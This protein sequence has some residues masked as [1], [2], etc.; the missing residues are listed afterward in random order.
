MQDE[1]A[2]PDF[3]ERLLGELAALHPQRAP[4]GRPVPERR[5]PGRPGP[6]RRGQP[7]RWRLAV[8]AVTGT[9]AAG[10]VAAVAIGTGPGS[11]PDPESEP[12]D[13][14]LVAER[15]LEATEAAGDA[16]VHETHRTATG[17]VEAETWYDE[18]TAA[19]RRL[20]MEPDG[21]PLYDSG[22]VAP[23]AVDAEPDPG[24]VR[25]E[26]GIGVCDPVSRLSMDAEGNITECDPGPVPPQP[27]VPARVV[28]HCSRSYAEVP[29]P[30]VVHPGS[31]YV[32]LFL[33][34]GDLVE[35]GTEEVDG[36]T[37]LR[38]RNHD[39]STVM[40]VDPETYLPASI[41]TTLPRSATDEGSA[42]TYERLPRT[43]ENMALL[44]P[45]VPD[46]FTPTSEPPVVTALQRC[47][48]GSPGR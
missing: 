23:P 7:G 10:V 28:D 15:V 9:V 8:A 43:E 45:E 47:P 24:L 48:E 30:V 18:V 3:E 31:D 39:A 6:G 38:I 13:V 22:E 17:R 35:D 41:T 26:V 37:L 36:R 40:L 2:M 25:P 16:I 1:L 34:T 14:E 12:V 46:G 42:T 4:Q 19:N 27:M 29:A 33:E 5:A 44:T 11:D 20:Q 21:T 32:T